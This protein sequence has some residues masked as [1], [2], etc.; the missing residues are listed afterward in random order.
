VLS[1]AIAWLLLGLFVNLLP[2]STAALLLTAVYG[3]FYGIV[4]VAGRP[5]PA[6]PGMAWQVP[7]PWVLDVPRWRRAVVWGALLGPGFATRNPYAGFGVLPLGLAAVGNVRS[8]VAVAAG[9]GIAHGGGRALAL[10]RDVRRVTT[11][12][13]LQS[14]LR[15]MYWRTFD[16]FALLVVSGAA[17][18]VC[19]FRL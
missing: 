3:A 9:I 6:P 1:A 7:S 15:S 17:A 10:L 4:E 16:G 18:A 8:G 19:V 13:Y 2:L 14:V 11:A 5:R 12:D